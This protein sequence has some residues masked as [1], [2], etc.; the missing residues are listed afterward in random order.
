MKRNVACRQGLLDYGIDGGMPIRP[1]S[2]FQAGQSMDSCCV[3]I[4]TTMIALVRMALISTQM[5]SC[6]YANIIILHA[7]THRCNRQSMKPGTRLLVSSF[8]IQCKFNCLL[9]HIHA[10][11][12]IQELLKT[13]K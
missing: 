7:E 2:A 9:M 4:I 5:N 8:V 11:I 10:T 3:N 12:Y 6:C 13:K 1:S